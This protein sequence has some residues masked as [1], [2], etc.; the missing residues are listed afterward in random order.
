MHNNNLMKNTAA[1]I[2]TPVITF[3]PVRS[4]I[5]L[6]GEL[7]ERASY[8]CEMNHA[9]DYGE[10]SSGFDGEVYEE[11]INQFKSILTKYGWSL[12]DFMEE[13]NRFERQSLQWYT[14][15]Q[16]YWE[17]KMLMVR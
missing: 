10:W 12:E 7:M 6:L 3:L 11:Y 9:V 4:L 2:G 8:S 13:I 15:N 17:I 1:T 16:N 14:L 5:R